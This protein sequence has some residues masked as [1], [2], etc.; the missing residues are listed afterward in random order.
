MGSGSVD[1]VIVKKR[2]RK[3]KS[4][5][6][7]AADEENKASKVARTFAG[8]Y[9][10]QIGYSLELWKKNSKVLDRAP[11]ADT[12]TGN[13]MEWSV[14]EVSSFVGKITSD[15][16]TIEKFHGQEIDGATFVCLCQEDLLHLMNIKMGIAIKIYNRILHLREEILL[17][18]IKI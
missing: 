9:G 16:K 7:A 6:V 17:K 8:D 13:P 15:E 18:F 2:G 14:A 11:V 5:T 12:S 1:D 4:V 3:R 10:P